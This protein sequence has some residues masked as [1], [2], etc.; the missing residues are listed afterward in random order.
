LI[1]LEESAF[2]PKYYLGADVGAT[3]TQVLVTNQDGEVSGLGVSGPG[4]HESVGYDGLQ[5]ALSTAIDQAL[6]HAGLSKGMI[7]GA[8]FG[9]AGYDWL[10]EMEATLQVIHS[11]ELN[12]AVEVVNDTILGLMAGAPHGWGIA[13]VSGTGCNCRGWDVTHRQEGRVIGRSTAAGEGAGSTELMAEVV[14]ALCREWTK[15]GSHTELTPVLIE[16][17]GAKDLAD[18]LEGYFE[19][20]YLL[21]GAA[22]PLV[23]QTAQNGDP[24]ARDVIHWAGCEL[25]EMVNSVVRQLQ[26]ETAEFDVVLVGSM[27]EGGE[28]LQEPMRQTV[29]SI[30]AG[31]RFLRLAVPPVYGGVLLGMD[32]DNYLITPKVRENLLNNN[33]L[34][35]GLFL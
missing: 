22:A 13:L 33:S 9:V 30:A 18:L 4:N 32:A 24:I 2:M 17:A 8:G 16:Y 25:G 19:G 28:L 5:N 26:F 31:A 10:S 21:D 12:S 11:M 6:S 29:H 23:F 27:F 1:Y 15:R 14:K 20:Q 3:K 34:S 7:A 35:M